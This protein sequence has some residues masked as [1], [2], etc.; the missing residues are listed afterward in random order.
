MALGLDRTPAGVVHTRFFEA[1]PAEFSVHSSSSR[2]LLLMAL[3]RWSFFSA[4]AS[5]GG[6]NG[7]NRQ[8]RNTRALENRA[9]VWARARSPLRDE[10]NGVTVIVS[11]RG[12]RV[13]DWI[14]RRWGGIVLCCWI[15][16]LGATQ[17]L[18]HK[19][20]DGGFDKTART[21]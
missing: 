16:A 6:S 13:A 17:P 14:D 2:F 7:D 3:L 21:F 18:R 12:G 1:E 11:M 5:A 10:L 20:V 8:N 4:S 9:L 19:R 15:F